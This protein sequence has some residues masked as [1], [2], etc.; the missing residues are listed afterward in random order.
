MSNILGPKAKTE[1]EIAAMLAQQGPADPNLDLW[2][3]VGAHN[4]GGLPDKTA[5]NY[6]ARNTSGELI[7]TGLLTLIN[8]ACFIP[9]G[10]VLGALKDEVS[11]NIV[12]WELTPYRGSELTVEQVRS[13][14]AAVELR[15]PGMGE[16]LVRHHNLATRMIVHDVVEVIDPEAD[17]DPGRHPTS[18]VAHKT[19]IDART[20]EP[21]V[22]EERPVDGETLYCVDCRVVPIVGDLMQFEPVDVSEGGGFRCQACYMAISEAEIDD[23]MAEHERRLKLANPDD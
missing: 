14:R 17:L 19:L 4:E 10:L 6:V 15:W 22:F 7:S 11:G 5:P 1:A 23:I 3:L 8:L 16:L 18:E 12:G 21:L 20:G 9:A 2:N 13:A